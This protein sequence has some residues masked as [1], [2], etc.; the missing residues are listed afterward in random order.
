[1]SL[2]ARDIGENRFEPVRRHRFGF[3]LQVERLH[4]RD[5]NG[6]LDQP[7]RDLPDH[8]LSRRGC[9]L[10]A[11]GHVDG[12]SGHETLSARRISG[13]HLARVHPDPD[14]DPDTVIAL[15]FGVQRLERLAHTA[16]CPNRADR[17]VLVRARDTEDRHDRVADELLHRATVGVDHEL[18]L[19]EEST[20]HAA[21]G[22]RIQAFTE[23]GR[24][25]DIGEQDRDDLAHLGGTLVRGT[26]RRGALL[27][28]PRAIRVL[29]AACSTEAHGAMVGHRALPGS[30]STADVSQL[31]RSA[32]RHCARP[33]RVGIL[34]Q[35]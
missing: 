24:A 29:F 6:I 7:V 17:I 3:A 35:P 10:E 27:T 30:G 32:V 18:H 16:R 21:K 14:L 25:G 8:D 34:R 15:Q 11:C 31:H 26:Q 4:G 13:D 33:R 20:H 22:L 2:V 19:V 28:E 9:L 12:V 23:R 1:M 5:L